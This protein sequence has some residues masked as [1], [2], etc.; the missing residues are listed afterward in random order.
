[1]LFDNRLAVIFPMGARTKTRLRLVRGRE[2]GD[3]ERGLLSL[4]GRGCRDN[5]KVLEQQKAV[6]QAPD[7]SADCRFTWLIISRGTM[8]PT[9]AA[10]AE[11]RP[12]T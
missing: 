3:G 12:S 6:G 5:N 8:V 4:L 1:M 10:S 2:S 9:V 11:S 7:Q